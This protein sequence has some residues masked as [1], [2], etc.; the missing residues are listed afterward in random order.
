MV[1]NDCGACV[2][3]FVTPAGVHAERRRYRAPGR[4]NLIGDHTDY[5]GG[6]VLPCAVDRH[7]GLTASPSAELRLESDRA[8]GVVALNADG[9]GTADGWGAY[10][11][12]VARELADAGRPAIG[13]A[14]ALT[15]DLPDG[16]GLSSSAALEV[17]LSVALCDVARFPLGGLELAA[18][19]QRA[20]MRAVGVPCG[21][22]DQAAIVLGRAGHAL[23]LDCGTLEH[24]YVGIPEELAVVVIDSGER[25][26]LAAS[27]YADRRTEVERG[28]A[29]DDG[30]VSRRR[31]RHVRSENERVRATVDALRRGRY[32]DLGEIFHASHQSLRTDFEVTTPRLD[33][34]VDLCYESG[35]LAARMTGGGFGGSLVALVRADVH[36]Q[37]AERVVARFRDEAGCDGELSWRRMTPADGAGRC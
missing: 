7:I 36:R 29:G 13:L 17:C 33:R 22:M 20:E 1:S 32:D 28:L 35:A 27:G 5:A 14:G 3:P 15:S 8:A 21:I 6:L 31:L 10:A 25:R 9:T 18:L 16:A 11:A 4:V 30:E 2:M 34:L 26:E 37:V 19:C 12:A 24:E 23:M